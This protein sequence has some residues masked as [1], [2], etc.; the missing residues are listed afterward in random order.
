LFVNSYLA[1]IYS[2]LLGCDK[3]IIERLEQDGII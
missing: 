2:A 1:E 3:K